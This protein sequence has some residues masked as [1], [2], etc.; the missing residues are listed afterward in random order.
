MTPM[1]MPSR[2][3]AAE[4]IAATVLVGE[5][6]RVRTAKEDLDEEKRD[7][8]MTAGELRRRAGMGKNG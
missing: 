1:P 2:R 3:E 8:A 5:S 4:V 7:D 6:R